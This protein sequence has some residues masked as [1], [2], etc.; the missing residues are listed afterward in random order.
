M[1]QSKALE[2]GSQKASPDVLKPRRNIYIYIVHCSNGTN[3][4]LHL[5][6]SHIIAAI[7]RMK[8]TNACHMIHAVWW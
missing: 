5:K 2:Y 4:T 1:E 3:G 6:W 8:I 7:E